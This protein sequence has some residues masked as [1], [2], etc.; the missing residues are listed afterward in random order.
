[1]LLLLLFSTDV[2]AGAFFLTKFK[3]IEGT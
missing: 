2:A 3:I 1:L